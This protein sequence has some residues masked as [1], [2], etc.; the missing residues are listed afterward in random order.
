MKRVFLIIHFTFFVSPFFVLCNPVKM[1]P[2]RPKSSSSMQANMATLNGVIGRAHHKK[3]MRKTEEPSIITFENILICIHRI[4]TIHRRLSL[5]QYCHNN[6]HHE[7][8]NDRYR[9]K[10]KC[11]SES[12]RKNPSTKYDA[13]TLSI[14]IQHTIGMHWNMI[15]KIQG[16]TSFI[17]FTIK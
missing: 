16:T 9:Y 14:S 13:Q 6:A 7:E 11:K 10:H 12:K 4:K 15:R 3:V 1:G 17:T 5:L 2:S 8:L